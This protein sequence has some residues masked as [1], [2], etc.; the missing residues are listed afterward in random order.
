MDILYRNRYIKK[1]NGGLRFVNNC[2][3]YYYRCRLRNVTKFNLHTY[4]ALLRLAMGTKMVQGGNNHGE[5]HCSL[6]AVG[7]HN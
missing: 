6:D 1:K 7:K 3:Y 5:D 2:G 4:S